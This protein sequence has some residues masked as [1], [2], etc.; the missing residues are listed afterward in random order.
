MLQEQIGER[1]DLPASGI[2]GEIVEGRLAPAGL[3]P[4][5]TS[6]LQQLFQV[7]D[8]SRYAPLRTPEEAGHHIHESPISMLGPLVPLAIGAVFAGYIGVPWLGNFYA[9]FVEPTTMIQSVH[10]IAWLPTWLLMLISGAVGIAGI[11]LA[12]VR[13]GSAP[14]EDPDRAVIPGWGVL[15][16]KYYVD[17]IYDAVFVK[18]LREVGRVFF[19]TDRNGIDNL[20]LLISWIPQAIGGM[21]RMFQRG[22][23]QGYALGMVGGLALILVLWK[24]LE[25]KA[26]AG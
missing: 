5:A 25:A 23:L 22:A 24:W 14:Q 3:D 17:E 13:Y 10:H 1:L 4:E 15:H 9:H 19:A 12:Y 7:C 26:L 11:G 16:A 6:H 20:L 18:P 8:Q 21:A 2:T